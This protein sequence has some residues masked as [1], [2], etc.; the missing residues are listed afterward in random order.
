MV[1]AAETAGTILG[2]LI[3]T[4]FFIPYLNSFQIAFI[5]IAGNLAI[6][7]FFLARSGKL[8][9]YALFFMIMATGL[10]YSAGGI[11][12]LHKLSIDKQWKRQEVLEYRNSIYGNIVVTEREG[13]YTFFYNGIPAITAP[14][15]DITFVQEFGNIP[16]LFSEEPKEVLIIGGGAGGL[17]N[18]I[19][20]HP[21]SR[22]DYVELDPQI[23]KLVRKYP[24]DLTQRELSDSR[25]NV[26]NLDGR[27]FLKTA[28][29]KYDAVLI[30]LSKPQDL[31]IN[32][33]FT[34]EFFS[35]AQGR[36][37]KGGVLAF[38]LPGS[39]TY[40]SQELKDL[41]A[42]ILNAL[43]D[44]YPYVRVIPG[45]YN[46]FLASDSEDIS[47]V[48]PAQ[49][50]QRLRQR[51]IKTD[52]LVPGYLEYRL[53][54]RW[55]QWFGD[56]LK[57]ATRQKNLDLRPFA[58]LEMVMFWNKQFAPQLGSVFKALTDLN[59]IFVAIII[60]AITLLL[61]FTRPNIRL[62]VAYG[63][64]TTGFF[65]M[66]A[67]LLLVFCFQVYYGYLYQRI[68]ILISIFMAGIAA[69][70]ILAG[71]LME[72][73]RKTLR[74]FIGLEL[75]IAL[76]S[77]ILPW[78]IYGLEGYLEHAY[79][80][81]ISLFFIPGLLLG[82]E[83]PLAGKIYLGKK[84]DAGRVAGILY[85]ADLMGGWVAG[86]IGGILLLPVLGLFN[87]CMIMVM[88]KASSLLLLCLLTKARI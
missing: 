24:S 75:V 40:L 73:S 3:L 78:L 5:I 37:N 57:G 25:V 32:R 54:Q 34:R 38:C 61:I 1:Y 81:F 28:A 10:F 56:S 15:P 26:I 47:A 16:L 79:G 9:R 35:L 50:T 31:S 59:I 58:V 48:G 53:D 4:Y 11:D 55:L 65:G 67:N 6:C 46:M 74:L 51:N 17:I 21:V 52:V 41:N 43:R 62:A 36:M 69:G 29:V 66:L 76:F 72:E 33:F 44:I 19:L 83:F 49:L 2:G 7:L 63:I 84:D 77:F 80:F 23:I 13:Q 14:Y 86:M 45:D 30:G 60:L 88:F 71:K 18:E 85:G 70:S 27:F 20:K 64:A 12:T 87:T 22:V 8:I 39:L 42:C 82:L 68:G